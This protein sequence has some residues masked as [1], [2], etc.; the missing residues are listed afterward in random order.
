MG[1]SGLRA[2]LNLF[3]SLW[4]ESFFKLIDFEKEEVL[5]KDLR[6]FIFGEINEENLKIVVEIQIFK[7]KLNI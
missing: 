6:E 2:V 4:G 3:W 7:L 5:E 1:Q